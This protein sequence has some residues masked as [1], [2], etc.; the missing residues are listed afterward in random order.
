MSSL[1]LHVGGG[2]GLDDPE[3]DFDEMVD[4]DARGS[5]DG[6]FAAPESMDLD[7]VTPEVMRGIVD[8][9]SWSTRRYLYSLECLSDR[10]YDAAS[11]YL[12]ARINRYIDD[13][14]D[15]LDTEAAASQTPS[16]VA[17]IA[18]VEDRAWVDQEGVQG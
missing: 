14:N 11:P 10:C 18:P 16:A 5:C 13:L 7:A 15:A 2:G 6:P 3:G 1:Q 8:Q 17:L 12:Q 4:M 9:L